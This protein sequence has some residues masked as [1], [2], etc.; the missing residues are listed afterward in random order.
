MC[1]EHIHIS[2]KNPN[3]PLFKCRADWHLKLASI[4]AC[5]CVPMPDLQKFNTARTESRPACGLCILDLFCI[6]DLSTSRN[7]WH[8]GLVQL[9]LPYDSTHAHVSSQVPMSRSTSPTARTFSTLCNSHNR[10]VSSL[11]FALHGLS[12]L[13]GHP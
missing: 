4:T 11:R 3:V 1:T 12:R 10:S 7:R 2:F 5:I 8:D 9:L 13:S 6:L